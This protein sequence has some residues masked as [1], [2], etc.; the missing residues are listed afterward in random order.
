VR[1]VDDYENYFLDVI[2]KAG[3]GRKGFDLRSSRNFNLVGF[4]LIDLPGS[5]GR[6][7]VSV[8]VPDIAVE[9]ERGRLVKRV[10]SGRRRR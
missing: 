2:L 9:A 1:T 4:G 3:K 8:D 7:M 10:L 5:G 6:V